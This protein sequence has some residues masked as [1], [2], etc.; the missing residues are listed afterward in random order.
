[1]TSTSIAVSW[2]N[3]KLYMHSNFESIYN[4]NRLRQVQS[5]VTE[6]NTFNNYQ[7]EQHDQHWYLYGTVSC[8]S[9]S[10]KGLHFQKSIDYSWQVSYANNVCMP[11]IAIDLQL[12][13]TTI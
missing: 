9:V 8:N 12:K 2:H 13:L 3:A 5:M 1:M 7:I 4:D 10:Q 11:V 6:Y